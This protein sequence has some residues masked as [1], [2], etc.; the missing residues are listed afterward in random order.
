MGGGFGSGFRGTKGSHKDAR[1]YGKPGQ[2][3]RDGSSETL[4]GPDGRAFR[5]R[6]HTDHGYPKDH[7]NPHD[8][9][10]EWGNDGN[11]IFEKD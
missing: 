1:L 4:I 5:E 10:I 7:T 3:N 8:H 2:V 9:V 6:H 11:P